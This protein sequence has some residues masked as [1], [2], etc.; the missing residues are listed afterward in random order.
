MNEDTIDISGHTSNNVTE[1]AHIDFDIITVC[2][3]ANEKLPLI[4]QVKM[5]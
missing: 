3:H 1:Y 2:D 5:P 4:F